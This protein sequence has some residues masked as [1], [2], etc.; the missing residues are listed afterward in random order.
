[1]SNPIQVIKD[2]CVK[3]GKLQEALEAYKKSLEINPENADAK[4]N[5]E[6]TI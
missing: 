4:Y 3:Q 6:L 2:A 1:M 5:K